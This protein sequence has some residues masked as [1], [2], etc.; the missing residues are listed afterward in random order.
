MKI[1]SFE[2]DKNNLFHAIIHGVSRGEIEE[3]VLGA[4]LVR[5]ARSG[6]YL[7][8]GQTLDGR[9]VLVVFQHK[10]HGSVRPFSAR[11]MTRNEKIRLKRWLK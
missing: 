4:R 1:R 3:V 11:P 5:R 8:Y 6:G 2:W 10:G 9:Y 7:A